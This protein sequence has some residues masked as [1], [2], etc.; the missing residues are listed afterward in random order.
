MSLY[1]YKATDTSGKIIKGTLEGTDEKG[2]AGKVQDMG[3]IPINIRLAGRTSGNGAEGMFTGNLNVLSF[4]TRIST[5]DVMLFTQDLSALLEAGLPV[6]RALSILGN[7]TEKEKFRKIIREVLKSVEGGSYLSDAMAKYPHAFSTF[8]VNMIRAGEAGGVLDA[9][10][11]RLGIFLESAQDISDYIKSALIYPVFLVFVGGISII[12]LMTFVIPKFSI[13]FSDM[14]QAIPLSTQILLGLSEG[15]R[16]YWWLIIGTMSLAYFFLQQYAKTPGGRLRMDTCKINFP[17]GGE[18]VR[19]VEVARFARTLGTL[20]KSGVPILQALDLVK[21]II[22][23]QVIAGSMKKIRERVKE[24]ERLSKP[25]EDTGIFPSL[26]VQMITVGE[27]SGRLDEMLLRVADNYE[28]VVRNMVKRFISLLEPVM[29][30][31]MGVV[32]GFI[33]ISMLMAIFSMNEIPF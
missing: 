26:A 12:I 15:L 31:I 17:I 30:L 5:K 10:L 4:A 9:V 28:K 13:I 3:Y 33:I 20:V 32:V 29:I 6:D 19:K 16:T 22:G 27:E 11:G 21:D 24:G 8:Y 2:V 25:L 14:G 23:N 7:V 1:S 18:L